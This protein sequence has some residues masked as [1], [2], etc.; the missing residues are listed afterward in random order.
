MAKQAKGSNRLL[1][2]LVIIL[3]TAGAACFCYPF[4][5]TA[6]N[7]VIMTSRRAEADREAA[8]NAAAQDAKRA[9][10]NRALAETGLRPGQDPFNSEQKVKQAYVK[11]HLIGR[12]AI[13][14]IEVDLPLF[15]T[16]N[17]TLLDQGAVVLPG[18]S[19][20]R[21]GKNTHTVISAHG[22]LP[23]KRY[24]TGLKKLK[25]GQQFLI[26]VN[27]KKLAYKVFRIQTV[28]PD[29]TESLQI[30]S[31]QDLATLMTCTPYMINS[32]RLLVTGKRVPYT[33]SLGQAAKAAD[34]WRFWKSAAIIGGVLL[35]AVLIVWLARRYLRRQRRS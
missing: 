4:A 22:G 29:Q 30:E 19:Y 3:F 1:R 6:I 23:T 10:E 35:L 25:K 7:E 21:G 9:S 11:K 28:K 33:E 31:G 15:D 24:F 14:K 20:P 12:I 13:P 34:Q 27:G 17:N 16:T 2:W 5:A 8:K 32:H 26:E 18:T